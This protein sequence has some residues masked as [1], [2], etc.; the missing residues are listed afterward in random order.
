MIDVEIIKLM[1][2]EDAFRAGYDA[3]WGSAMPPRPDWTNID[4][5]AFHLEREKA[6]TTWL[7]KRDGGEG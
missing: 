6:L 4:N 1:L 5:N 2:L 7:A 3:G